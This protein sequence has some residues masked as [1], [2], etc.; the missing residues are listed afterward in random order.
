MGEIHAV[1]LGT[2][3]ARFDP[4]IDDHHHLVCERAACVRDVDVDV[5]GLARARADGSTASPSRAL[6]VVFRGR[7]RDCRTTS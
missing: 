4:N 2:G 6:D 5:S 1:D 3:S 7:V